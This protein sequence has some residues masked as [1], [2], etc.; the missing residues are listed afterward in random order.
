M[1]SISNNEIPHVKAGELGIFEV[2][3]RLLHRLFHHANIKCLEN[4]SVTEPACL[5]VEHTVSN[6][7]KLYRIGS[8]LMQHHDLDVRAEIDPCEE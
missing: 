1:C 3:Q 6:L 4:G 2:R 5:R 7:F 8:N